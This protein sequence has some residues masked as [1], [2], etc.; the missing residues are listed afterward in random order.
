MEEVVFLVHD[1]L[2]VCA[3]V[4]GPHVG[5]HFRSFRAELAIEIVGLSVVIDEDAWIDFVKSFDCG[6]LGERACRGRT[7]GDIFSAV[8]HVEIE[9]CPG[10][11]EYCVRRVQGCSPSE[12]AP[13]MPPCAQVAGGKQVVQVRTV[14][15]VRLVSRAVDVQASVRGHSGRGVCYVHTH[16]RYWIL[17]IEGC[18]R[19]GQCCAGRQQGTANDSFV[20]GMWLWLQA[21]LPKVYKIN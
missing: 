4:Q 16:R 3:H 9:V 2:N 17:R 18:E 6:R 7:F 5:I 12:Y 20:H 14:V 15:L 11:F 13:V 21:F 8:G 1:S 10:I 19:E